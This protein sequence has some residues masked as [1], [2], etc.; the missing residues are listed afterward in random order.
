MYRVMKIGVVNRQSTDGGMEETRYQLVLDLNVNARY[1][2]SSIVSSG[3]R[4]YK[5]SPP[6]KEIRYVGPCSLRGKCDTEEGI[7]ECFPGFAGDDCSWVNALSY[8]L[9]AST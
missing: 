1:H 7:C 9:Q 2:K 8:P 3:A 5:F 6:K 4:L